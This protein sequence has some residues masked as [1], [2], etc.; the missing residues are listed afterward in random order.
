MSIVLLLAAMLSS[1]FSPV[2]VGAQGS[3]SSSPGPERLRVIVTVKSS[4]FCNAMK[5]MTLPLAFITHQDSRAMS[6]MA[7]DI[8]RLLEKHA[9]PEDAARRNRWS[10]F[11][12][13]NSLR[14]LTWD[15]NQNLVLADRV[16]NDSWNRYPRGVNANVDAMRQ[17]LQNIVDLQRAVVNKYTRVM[18]LGDSCV[19]SA[20]KACSSAIDAT[21]LAQ[22]RAG[23]VAALA[24]LQNA[25]D[26]EDLPDA[27][28]HDVA[29]FGSVAAIKRQLDLQQAAFAEEA[30]AAGKTC[31]I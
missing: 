6:A 3:P 14:E 20:Q 2:A 29:H 26:P 22:L 16:M 30:I 19:S 8:E 23:D 17:R 1:P 31:G 10:S 27:S 7:D 12:A 5:S 13:T 25:V 18:S 21:E 9:T 4:T 11:T 28:A 24:D 15:L